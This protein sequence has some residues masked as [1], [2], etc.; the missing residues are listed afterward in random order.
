M[1][2]K[3]PP[4]C[5]RCGKRL[6]KHKVWNAKTGTF[7]V[8][9]TC[10]LCP[11]PKE[12]LKT[13]MNQGHIARVR[14]KTTNEFER[15]QKERQTARHEEEKIYEIFR[16]NEGKSSPPTE[17]T[18]NSDL[19]AR[20]IDT[21]EDLGEDYESKNEPDFSGRG[22]FGYKL[23][24][25]DKRKLNTKFNTNNDHELKDVENE[26]DFNP[27]ILIPYISEDLETEI[28]IY[29]DE[30]MKAKSRIFVSKNQPSKP[31]ATQQEQ[32]RADFKSQQ[33]IGKD[34]TGYV[35][36]NWVRFKMDLKKFRTSKARW[37]Y[38]GNY[39]IGTDDL[40]GY[41]LMVTFGNN[42]KIFKNLVIQA[43]QLNGFGCLVGNT[44]ASCHLK[45]DYP[46]NEKAKKILENICRTIYSKIYG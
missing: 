34:V 45:E 7:E 24:E 26:L 1:F 33:I 39:E 15:E 20:K 21:K 40:P 2:E 12:Q 6:S 29:Y 8:E 13:K 5:P 3:K 35:G 14:F 32:D 16:E 31:S 44:S 22:P 4:K 17:K 18:N 43:L 37:V 25:S 27:E 19:I 46:T 28:D 23:T 30:K 41:T 42:E 11:P 38:G 9:T 10:T 36:R